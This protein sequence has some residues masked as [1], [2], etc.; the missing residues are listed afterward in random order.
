[1]KRIRWWWI[2]L[3]GA[4]AEFAT[5]ALIM[6]LRLAD[7]KNPLASDVQLSAVARSAF[8]VG[9]LALLLFFAWWVARKATNRPILHGLLVGVV[10]IVT[11][12]L[13]TIG[14]PIPL[15]WSYVFVHAL[16]LLGGVTGG[17]MAARGVPKS[18]AA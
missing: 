9:V 18:I 10:A 16:K 15:T 14:L 7:G 4:L 13:L 17:Y 11:Y 1:M 3:G 12:E 6:L 2:L 8:L 5:L